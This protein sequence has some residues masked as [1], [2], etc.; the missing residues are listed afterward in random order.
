MDASSLAELVMCERLN[1]NDIMFSS[2]ETPIEEYIKASELGAIINLD[3]I[4]HIDFIKNKI[5]IPKKMCVRYNPGGVF[6]MGTSIMDNPG[7][8][9]YG[10]T[11]QQL[12]DAI[13]ELKKLGV[14]SFG[15]HSFL[16]SNTKTNDYYPTLAKILFE[17]EIGRAHV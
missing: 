3:D 9:K 10:M 1:I 13:I 5:N 6:Q 15:I 16:A 11:K 17:L 14:E 7:E 2:N 8:A 12:I 4:T